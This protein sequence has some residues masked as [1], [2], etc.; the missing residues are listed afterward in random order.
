MQQ[1]QRLRFVILQQ[2]TRVISKREQR[3]CLGI[4]ALGLSLE[5][6]QLLQRN[7]PSLLQHLILSGRRL[8]AASVG[9]RL[10]ERG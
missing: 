6:G 2:N 9:I 7:G 10:R 5:R 1:A 3:F 4:A 8:N